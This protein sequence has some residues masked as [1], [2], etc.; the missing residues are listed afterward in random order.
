MIWSGRYSLRN[1]L[2]AIAYAVW[3]LAVLAI[4]WATTPY[5]IPPESYVAPQ[6]LLGAVRLLFYRDYVF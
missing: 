5:L 6:W 1:A 4:S 3:T 2:G